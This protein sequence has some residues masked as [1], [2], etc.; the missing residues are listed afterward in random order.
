LHV[1]QGD[2]ARAV[3]VLER[4]LV[5]LRMADLPL[6]FPFVAGPLGAA[7]ALAGRRPEALP[8]LEEAIQRA[9]NMNLRAHQSLRLTWPGEARA[10][11]A[12]AVEAFRAL[13]MAG[14]LGRADAVRAELTERR[15]G[16]ADR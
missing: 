3:P 15:T 4:G 5:V 12:A 2:L 10:E 14:W 8:L 1:L 9:E 6:L 11:V 7:Y 13:E 16:D